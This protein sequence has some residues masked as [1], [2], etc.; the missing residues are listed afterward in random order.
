MLGPVGG[1][2]PREMQPMERIQDQQQPPL[3]NEAT[4]SASQLGSQQ[5]ALRQ[6]IED[7][8]SELEFQPLLTNIARRACQLLEAGDG[9]IGLYDAERDLIRIAAVYKMPEG[10]LG[11]EIRPGEGLAGQVLERREPVVVERYGSLPKT[12]LPQLEQN[13]VLGVPIFWRQELIGFFGIGAPPPRSFDQSDVEI[14]TLFARHAAIAIDN[15]ERFRRERK[16][17]E[18]LGLLARVVRILSTG[19]DL[20]PLLKDAAEATHRL[21]G[22]PNVAI[23]IIDQEDPETLLLRAAGGDYR[24]LIHQEYRLPVAKGLM[25]AAVRKKETILVNDVQADPRYLPT[26]GSQAIRAELAVPIVLGDEVLGV[27]NIEGPEPFTSEDASVL[28]I[29]ADHLAVAIQN[30]SLFGQ[31]RRLAV[32]EERQRLARD[33]H[34]SVTQMLFSATLIAQAVPQAYRRDPEEGERRLARLL[35]LNRSALAEMRALLRELRPARE[36]VKLDTEEFPLPAIF[37]V[38]RD[39]VLAVL[40]E[41]LREA[42]HDGLSVVRWWESYSRQSADLEEALFRVAQEALNNVIKHAEAGVVTVTLEASAESV[43]LSVE[44]D[45]CGFDARQAR[46]RSAE[47]RGMGLVSMGER[48]RSLGG[49][50]RLHS[51]PGL[52]TRVEAEIPARPASPTTGLDQRGP[53]G[54]S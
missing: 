25:G 47:E 53:E 15:A 26:P 41:V 43:S 50:F 36:L 32:M 21:L 13:T 12:R 8:S 51:A 1:I 33:L 24:D 6:V 4:A 49:T 31:T 30:A 19:L 18:Q 7:I 35:E 16:R 34:D 14:L 20:D 23:P 22:Y 17:A 11:S 10:E 3:T 28:E 27:L 42:E 29:L 48:V 9:S 45:G 2:L 40:D 44:D 37:R 5:E 39:G 54:Q 38:R 52:G 46:S